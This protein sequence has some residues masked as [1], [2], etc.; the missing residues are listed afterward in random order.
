MLCYVMSFW[1]GNNQHMRGV[2]YREIYD[3]YLPTAFLRLVKRPSHQA[4]DTRRVLGCGMTD[5]GHVA[6]PKN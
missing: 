2:E 1:F 4:I 3:F 5:G 6:G